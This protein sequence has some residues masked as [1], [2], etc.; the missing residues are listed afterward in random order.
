MTTAPAPRRLRRWPLSWWDLLHEP[1][2]VTAGATIVYVALAAAGVLSILQPP[3]TI[4]SELGEIV[5]YGWAVF[6][7]LGGIL[8]TVSAPGGIWWLERVGLYAVGTFLLIYTLTVVNLQ[9]SG[10]GS[11]WMQLGLICMGWYFIV[12]RWDRTRGAA[13]DPTRGIHKPSN[14]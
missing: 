13:L 10:S 5:T 3:G 4:T 1:A 7:V 8:G 2:V 14:A 9:I 12:S 11:R 6:A